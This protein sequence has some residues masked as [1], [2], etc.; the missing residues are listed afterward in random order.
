MKYKLTAG[1]QHM[2]IHEGGC[3]IVINKGDEVELSEATGQRMMKRGIVV[4]VG[5]VLGTV[6]KS[7]PTPGKSM[8]EHGSAI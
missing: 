3:D 8:P 6:A 5:P 2:T 7:T 4:P 1:Y